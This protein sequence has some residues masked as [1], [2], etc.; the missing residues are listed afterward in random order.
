VDLGR[1]ARGLRLDEIDDGRLAGVADPG[2]DES[3]NSVIDLRTGRQEGGVPFSRRRQREG[4]D[5]LS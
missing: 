3:R 4:L 5:P 2:D 1:Y